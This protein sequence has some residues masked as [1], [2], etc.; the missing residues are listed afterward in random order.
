MALSLMLLVEAG[1]LIRS[2]A[3][4]EGQGL[5]IR[6]DHL[7]KGHFY[8]PGV[9]YR[10]SDAIT[11]FCDRF[12]DSVRRLPGVRE[13]SVTTIYP[14]DN[15]WMQMLDI[16]GHPPAR[17]QDI[18]IAQFGLTDAHFLRTMGIPL[19][20]GRD[21]N[22][23]DTATSRTV[24]LISEQLAQRYFPKQD[25]I[26]MRL[27]IGPPESLH[28]APGSRITD[29]A[30]VTIVGMIGDF[31]NNG[32]AALPEPQIIVPYAQHPYVNYGFK[33]IVIRTAS[34]PH[35]MIPAVAQRLHALD[36]DLPFAQAQTMDELVAQ[37]TGSE[38]FTAELLA[39]FAAAG[40]ALAAVGVYG[41]VAFL[42]AQRTRELAVRI[43]VGAS[44]ADVLWLVL[45]EGLR[46]A[47]V[48]A[49]MGLV[50]VWATQKL[51][52]GLLFEISAV[53]PLTLT[54]SGLF[55]LAIILIACWVPARR[56]ARVDPCLALRAE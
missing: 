12:G 40:L 13:A 4:L 17:V 41:V 32:L 18:P 8:L 33:D 19:V 25:P 51:I 26:G 23:S 47:A 10:N 48:G 30:D 2:I 27:H 28:I 9:R 16:P 35:A 53:D 54:G 39:F 3:R 20:R 7:L 29:S 6:P 31:R 49:S 52:S 1:L 45:K 43:A 34:D 38:R 56:V 22:E 24:A 42:V 50:G 5:G 55:L 37:V 46:A 44:V 15:G 36:A 14:P 11:R 21:F